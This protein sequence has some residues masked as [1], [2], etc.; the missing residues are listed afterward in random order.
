MWDHY[1]GVNLYQLVLQ[2]PTTYSA[3][4]TSSSNYPNGYINRTKT[5]LSKML[6]LGYCFSKEEL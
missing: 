4:N 2:A 1:L 3:Y 6:E 5:V